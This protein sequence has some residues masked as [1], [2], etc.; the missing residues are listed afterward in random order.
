MSDQRSLA[1]SPRRNPRRPI[2]RQSACSGSVAVNWRNPANCGALQPRLAQVGRHDRPFGWLGSKHSFSFGHHH[3]QANTHHGLLMVN[4]DD[5]VDAG[6]G[7]ETHPHR[8]MEIVTWVLEGSLVHRIHRPQPDHLSRPGAADECGPRNP[9]P[10]AP[11]RRGAR[12]SVPPPLRPPRR[13]DPRRR[14]RP[15]DRGRRTIHRHRRSAGR[16]D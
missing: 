12:S 11:E 14:R 9:T 13:R 8:D 15:R 10:V 1:T 3:G 4:N 6:T 5:I 7:F 2:R 16:R